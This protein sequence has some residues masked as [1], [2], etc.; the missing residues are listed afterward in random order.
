[1]PMNS[2]LVRSELVQCNQHKIAG[3]DPLQI[4]QPFHK[5][6]GQATRDESDEISNPDSQRAKASLDCFRRCRMKLLTTGTSTRA[7]T[8]AFHIAFAGYG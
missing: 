2:M 7:P 1:M 4:R 8:E 3:P 6:I 5:H